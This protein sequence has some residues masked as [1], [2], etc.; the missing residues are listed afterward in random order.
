MLLSQSFV[1]DPLFSTRYEA[2]DPSK[3]VDEVRQPPERDQR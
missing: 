2:L 3:I 1:W